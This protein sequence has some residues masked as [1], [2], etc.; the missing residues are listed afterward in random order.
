MQ[1]TKWLARK[2]CEQA[3]ILT[4]ESPE[5]TCTAA[6]TAAARIKACAFTVY[7][8]RSG[9]AFD[10][11]TTTVQGVGSKVDALRPNATATHICGAVEQKKLTMRHTCGE[12][13]EGEGWG[14]GAVCDGPGAQDG[15]GWPRTA[16]ERAG[17][18]QAGCRAARPRARMSAHA[19]NSR[20]DWRQLVASK[21][22][23]MR[24]AAAALTGVVHVLPAQRVNGACG[25]W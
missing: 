9:W 12:G 18:G 15:T 25:R 2:E 13:V 14:V 22:R 6:S 8:F 4:S 20:H 3:C 24:Q 17:I 11:T 16:Q 23:S 10:A 5:L 19:T 21:W 1:G 7:A